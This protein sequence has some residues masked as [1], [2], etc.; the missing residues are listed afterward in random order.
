M[1]FANVYC[2]SSMLKN[3][4]GLF[5]YFLEC[6]VTS[7][8]ILFSLG[9]FMWL[10]IVQ[11]ILYDFQ[12]LTFGQLSQLYILLQLNIFLSSSVTRKKMFKHSNL[13][14]LKQRLMLD[15]ACY[16]WKHCFGKNSLGRAPASPR[17]MCRPC[18]WCCLECAEVCI[19]LCVWRRVSVGCHLVPDSGT[20]QLVDS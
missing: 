13:Q 2:V 1:Y 12:E 19:Y 15:I 8:C 7:I 4:L 16:T 9:V 6:K 20:V 10:W 5:I 11:H 18:S 3:L 14:I 17:P